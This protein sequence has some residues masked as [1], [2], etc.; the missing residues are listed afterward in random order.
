VLTQGYWNTHGCNWPAPFVPGAPD[1]TDL[2]SNGVPDNL[3]GQC[4]VQGNNPNAQ[5][6]CD[7]VNTILVGTIDYTQCDLLCS[8]DQS[9]QGNAVRILAHQLIAA[10]LNILGGATDSDAVSDPLDPT[11]PYNGWTVAQI[12]AE[13]NSLIGSTDILT[14]VQGTQCSGPNADP[15]GCA[16]V[17]LAKL[18]DLYNNGDGGV[19]H[20][21]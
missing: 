11:N 10:D 14:G 20:C 17:K 3:E 7:G 12:V 8:L 4:G 1:P 18:L 21:P 16:M 6:P 2:D 15:V 13:A 19:P 9:A 5:C